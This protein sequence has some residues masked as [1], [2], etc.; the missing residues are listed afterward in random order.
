MNVLAQLTANAAVSAGLYLLLGLSFVIPFRV[1]RFFHFEHGAIFTAAAYLVFLFKGWLGFSLPAAILLGLVISTSLGCLMDIFIYRP[2]R[3]RKASSLIL[4]LASLG[5]FT[6]FQNVIS[7]VFGDDAK[8]IR[9]GIL[10]EGII[11]WGARITS[12]QWGIILVSVALSAAVTLLLKTTRPGKAM[13][14]VAN[15]PELACV[16]GIDS[17]RVILWS[18]ALGSALAGMTGIL[19]A[20]DVDMNPTMGMKA[21]LM[22]VVTVIIGGA[23]STWGIALAAM[24]LGLAQ[25]FGVWK[26]SSHWQ[27]GIA[28]IILL[29]FLIFR[30]EGFFGR[31]VKKAVV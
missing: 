30:P 18:F 7:M 6:V 29:V 3:Q 19:V 15:D 10:G 9:P 13:R 8:I 11:L 17:E 5:L 4:M 14:A 22:G 1:A 26:I 31:K 28:F 16:S 12:I 23:G 25:H 21:L 20:L 24:L 2:L 27:D